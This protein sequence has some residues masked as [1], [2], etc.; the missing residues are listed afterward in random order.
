MSPTEPH[1][2]VDAL[3]AECA[4]ALRTGK[5]ADCLALVERYPE[6]ASEISAFIHDFDR[7]EQKFAPLRQ[8]T[9]ST[10]CGAAETPTLQ[11]HDDTAIPPPPK[12]G[13]SFG[14]YELLSEVARGGMGIVYK[15]RQRSL[16]RVVALKMVLGGG[17]NATTERERFLVEARAVARLNHPHIVPIYEVGELGGQPYFTMEFFA[18]GSLRERM[19]EFRGDQK[20]IAKLMVTAAR[21]VEHAHRRGI[22]HRDLKPGNVLLD[23]RRGPHV[24]DF[25]L[26]KR[27]DEESDLTQAG[28]IVGTP[29]YMA[30]EQAGAETDLTTAVD[31]YGLGAV[32]YEL[33]TGRPPFKG[34]TPV[35]TLLKTMS[36]QPERPRRL[37]ASVEP[38]L[39]TICLKCLEKDPLA[40]YGSADALADDLQRWLAGKPIQARRASS[41]ERLI[42][43]ARRQ[44]MLAGSLATVVAA[45][46]GLLILAGFLWQNAELRAQAVQNLDE[47]KTQLAQVDTERQQAETK[48]TEAENLADQQRKLADQQKALADKIAAGVGQ[49]EKDANAAQQKLEVAEQE[50]RRTIYAADMQLAHAAWQGDNFSTANELI[51]RHLDAA[52]L[53]DVRGFEWHYLNRQLQGA[54]LSWRDVSEKSRLVPIVGMAVSPDGKTLATAQAD[55]RLKLWNLADGKLLRT[56]DVKKSNIQFTFF[57][58]VTGVFFE[59]D[60]RRLVAI[61]RKGFDIRQMDKK[62]SE[63]MAKSKDFRIESLADSLEFQVASFAEKGPVR[64]ELFDANRLATSVFPKLSGGFPVLDDGSGLLVMAMDRSADGRFL[65]LAGTEMEAPS[66]N[67]K[68]PWKVAG[69]KLF[70]WDLKAGKVHG[71]YAASTPLTAVAFSPAGDAVAIATSDNAVGVAK[72]DF[73]HPPRRMLG[74]SGNVHALRFSHDGSRLASGAVDSLVLF[75]DVATAKEVDRFCGHTTPVSAVEFSR[76]DRTLISGAMDGTVKVWDVDRP[77]PLL[78]LQGHEMDVISLTFISDGRELL[79]ADFTGVMKRWR[80]PDGQLVGSEQPKRL[81]ALSVRLSSSGKFLARKEGIGDSFLVREIQSGKETRLT[82]KGHIPVPLAFSPDEKMIAAASVEPGGL[83]VWN[84]ADGKQ[85]ATLPLKKMTM[86]FA[87]SPDGKHVAAAHGKEVVLWD[88]QAG[89]SRRILQTDNSGRTAVA[90]SADGRLL[91]SAA[92]WGSTSPRRHGSV[93][94]WDL[95]TDQLQAE[96]VG[97]GQAVRNL[98]F[99]PNGRRLATAGTSTGPR[100]ML[101]LWDVRSGREVFSAKLP[102]ATITA[103]AFSGDGL[104]LAAA[105]TPLDMTATLTAGIVPSEILVWNATPIKMT[106]VVD[107]EKTQPAQTIA[108]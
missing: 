35:E 36:T 89:Q 19:E 27:L 43:W 92:G 63:A 7:I 61:T 13:A 48:K 88:W 9:G 103:M 10:P 81:N 33:L 69:G 8:L 84:L 95:Q 5:R 49:L 42:K 55:S 15:A 76:D 102:P 12:V 40:R 32:L 94:I 62:M 38:D 100:G 53:E 39:E 104:R 34:N 65:A 78:K 4:E 96:F 26:A 105:L 85:L 66:A 90:F 72:T 67:P 20:A 83:I 6:H 18:G 37:A 98:A 91:A 107:R 28:A 75:W 71:R 101:K 45:S 30:P 11:G 57:G 74:H 31:V 58:N 16:N 59:D 47:A 80:F 29:S 68:Q 25:G 79:S 14:D 51:D 97:A 87:F 106:A 3:I 23:E 93:Q 64:V 73:T 70:V 77:K 21:A 60:G 108:P 82:W 24:T 44:P 54:R 2:P 99:S 1:T 17:H 41:S 22:L 52:G 56:I 86:G 46:F 50:A